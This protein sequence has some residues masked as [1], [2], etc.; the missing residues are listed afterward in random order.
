MFRWYW[1]SRRR[2]FCYE[3]LWNR[4]G[5]IFG[6]YPG[7]ATSSEGN[8][9]FEGDLDNIPTAP[10]WLIAEMK[11]PPKVHQTRKDLDFSDRTE[12]EIAQ[13]IRNNYQENSMAGHLL[14]M[15]F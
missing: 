14:K 3:I 7:S 6:S 2:P 8:Y 1:R 4:Q 13:I 5:V 11:A 10:D 9:G 12:D 15:W